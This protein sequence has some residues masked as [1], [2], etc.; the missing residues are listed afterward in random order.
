MKFLNFVSS[1]VE[2]HLEAKLFIV[3]WLRS[4]LAILS[5][6]RAAF[7]LRAWEGW[8]LAADWSQADQFGTL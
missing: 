8:K 3:F 6:F 4:D 2:F 7:I 1:E 5:F